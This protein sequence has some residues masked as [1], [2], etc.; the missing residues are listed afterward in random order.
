M[1]IQSYFAHTKAVLDRYSNTAFVLETKV[2]YD[3]R[4]SE[5]GFL[6]GS[7]LFADGST[8][9]FKEYLDGPNEEVQKIMYSYHYQDAAQELI[10]RYDNARHQPALSF[11]E[12]KHVASQIIAAP[13][14]ELATILSEIF[15]LTKWI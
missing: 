14:P 3:S 6:H 1:S 15:I 4:P 11:L 12:H 7:I 9:F 5:Q 8:L 2:H 10:F 13:A